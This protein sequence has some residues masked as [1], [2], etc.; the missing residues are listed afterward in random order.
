MSASWSTENVNLANSRLGA[1]VLFATDEWFAVADNLLN[2][3]NPVFDPNAFCSQGKVMDGWESRR[4]RTPGHD[5]CVVKLGIPG[6]V[7]G[8]QL[9]T[10]WF[11]GNN[12]PKASV[13]AAHIE[14]DATAGDEWLPGAKARLQRGGGELGTAATPQEIEEADAICKKTATWHDL[15]P[16]HPLNPGYEG[17]SVSSFEAPA[18]FPLKRV[19]HVRLNYFPDGGVARMKIWG[20]VNYDFSQDIKEGTVMD[21]A[22]IASGGRGLGC[23][24]Q[25]YGVPRNLLQ[26][27]RGKDMGDGWETARHPDRPPVV[28]LDPSTGLSDTL[29]FDWC[30]IRLGAATDAVQELII[31][32]CHFKGNFP[33]SVLVEATS[34]PLTTP[35]KSMCTGPAEPVENVEWFTLL[36]RTRMGAD[37]IH[38]FSQAALYAGAS[39]RPVSHIRVSIFPDGGIMRV[40]VKGVPTGES[41]NKRQR[42]T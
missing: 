29:L 35:T 27:G 36:P 30:V 42:L 2:P 32:T 7:L 12:V 21:L 26:E 41:N 18:D 13:Q 34:A 24:N 28:K 17:Q 31:D 16:M 25:H 1:K 8:V 14:E 3:N 11:T 9:D 37:Q 5:W 6:E 19:T 22:A 33:E 10:R 40:R 20:M 39:P 23:S 4:R 15:V 38:S